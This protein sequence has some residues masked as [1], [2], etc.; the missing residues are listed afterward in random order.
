MVTS[1]H[2]FQNF[3]FKCIIYDHFLKKTLSP[4][5]LYY[6]IPLPP[7][8]ILGI[9]IT[10]THPQVLQS[11]TQDRNEQRFLV[12]EHAVVEKKLYS[13]ANQVSPF[14]LIYFLFQCVNHLFIQFHICLRFNSRP[15]LCLTL[16]TTMIMKSA[17]IP[18][19]DA[20]RT[21][22]LLM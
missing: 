16:R 9:Q 13:E 21:S 18:G 17:R 7:I 1:P 2:H 15:I 6:I 22:C 11:T 19:E 8:V 20:C 5:A 3:I 12:Q 4:C 14:D 10:H